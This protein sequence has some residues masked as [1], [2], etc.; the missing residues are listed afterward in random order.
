MLFDSHARAKARARAC[1]GM[2]VR[3]S[4]KIRGENGNISTI[5]GTTEYSTRR[6]I[7]FG[8]SVG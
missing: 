3:S 7:T 5:S 2:G 4:R 8:R 6:F 1:L